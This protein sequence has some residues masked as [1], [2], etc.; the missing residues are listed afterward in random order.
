MYGGVEAGGTTFVCA[1][2]NASGELHDRTRIPTTTPRETLRAVIT[3][4]ENHPVEAIGM[5]SFGPVD[6]MPDSP[7][8]GFITNTP[9][10]DWQ[11]TDLRSPLQEALGVPIAFDLDVNAAALGEQHWGTGQNVSSFVYITVGTGVG[12]SFMQDGRPLRGLLHP[13]MGHMYL[14]HAPDDDFD[15]CC[16]FHGDCLEGM[17]AAPALE[18]R[19]GASPADLP[20]EHPAWAMEAH[21]LGTALANLACILTPERFI[22]GGGVMHREVLF[23]SIRRVLRKRLDGYLDVAP[24]TEETD[25]YVVPAALGADA[26]VR[27][28][29]AM[30]HQVARRP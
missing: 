14:P 21:Y 13:E 29:L 4:F 23:P 20:D 15:G 8:Y 12:G 16:P 19:W 22:L 11:H 3:F 9:K 7:T 30:A 2:G 6:E 10:S 24:L 1:T 17:A 27:G 18:A 28:A 25:G 5:G 26:G